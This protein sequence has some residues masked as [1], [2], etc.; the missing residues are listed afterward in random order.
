[1]TD[2]ATGLLRIEQIAIPVKDLER[3]V[4]FYQKQAEKH[5]CETRF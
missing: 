1:M 2:Q 3:A 4:I 5:S